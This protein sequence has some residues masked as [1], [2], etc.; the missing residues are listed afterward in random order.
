LTALGFPLSAL[1]RLQWV[2]GFPLALAV[3][4]HNVVDPAGAEQVCRRWR[5]SNKETDRVVWLIEQHGALAGARALRWSALQPILIADGIDDLLAMHKV[6]SA[7]APED[8]AHCRTCLT[9]PPEQ[10]N[11]PPLLTGDDLLAHGIPAGPQFR[12][13]LSRVRAA[14]LDEQISSRAEALELVGGGGR[15]G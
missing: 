11:P 10:L 4:L 8:L 9:R 13:L 15:S 6:S 3:L 12:V 7:A 1:G 5:L 2:P 14:Q